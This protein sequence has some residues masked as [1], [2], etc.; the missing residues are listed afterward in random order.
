MY[1]TKQRA[2]Q[3]DGTNEK[4][5]KWISTSENDTPSTESDSSKINNKK[6]GKIFKAILAYYLLKT[7]MS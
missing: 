4:F 7:S 3:Q 5:S 6:L 1:I 2:F